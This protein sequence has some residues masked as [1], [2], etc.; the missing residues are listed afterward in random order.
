ML[1]G[2][3]TGLMAVHKE[4]LAVHLRGNSD[5]FALSLKPLGAAQH[6]PHKIDM[7]GHVPIKHAPI[8]TSC[9]EMLTQYS[10]IDKMHH[11]GIIQPSQ[12]PWAFPMVLV[13]KKDS[14]TQFCVDYCA[15]NKIMKKD[16]YPLPHIKDIL[17]GLQ[18][19]LFR[20]TFDLVSGYWQIPVD[21]SDIEKTAFMTRAGTWEFTVM[22]FGLTNA[23]STFQRDMDMVLAG[24]TWVCALVYIDDI[25]VYSCM[26]EQHLLD[27]SQVFQR[28]REANMYVKPSKCHLCKAQLPFLGHIV[29][30]DGIAPDPS[31]ITAV[32]NMERPKNATEVRTFLGLTNYYRRFMKGYAEMAAPLN[33]LTSKNAE[34]ASQ[35][36]WSPKCELAFLLLKKAMMTA[37]VLSFLDYECPFELYTNTSQWWARCCHN[38]MMRDESEWSHMRASSSRKMRPIMASQSSNS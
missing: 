8:C 7:Q 27:M 10:E 9:M 11:A 12:S 38:M 36:I 1:K 18:G 32:E 23:P 21:P 5:V 22:P 19:S 29:S 2:A 13:Q 20:S 34:K 31:K 26:F 14:T 16:S 33:A 35:F 17:D 3:D 28:L 25:I 24:L 4:Q 30:N 37:L 6:I 15:L